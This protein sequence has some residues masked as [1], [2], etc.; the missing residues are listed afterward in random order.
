MAAACDVAVWTGQ[1]GGSRGN[2]LTSFSEYSWL[3]AKEADHYTTQLPHLST[4]RS[5]SSE[6]FSVV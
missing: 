1:G 3:D 4:K 6:A 5:L 2:Q